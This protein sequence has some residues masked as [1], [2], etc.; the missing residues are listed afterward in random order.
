[1]LGIWWRGLSVTGA[2]AGLVVGGTLAV[3]AVLAALI[4]GPFD[5]QMGDAADRTGRVVRADR[6][7]RRDHGLPCDSGT[8]PPQRRADLRAA[9]TRQRASGSRSGR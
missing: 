1:M 7:R 9:C 2:M 5:S 8:H 4:L 6:V 3:G